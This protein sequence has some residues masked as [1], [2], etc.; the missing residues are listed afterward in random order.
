MG[1]TI[2][3]I[4]A[5]VREL[6]KYEDTTYCLGNSEAE[7]KCEYSFSANEALLK[8]ISFATDNT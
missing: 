5:I 3:E 8:L 1:Y 4:A 7:E 2:E 6:L